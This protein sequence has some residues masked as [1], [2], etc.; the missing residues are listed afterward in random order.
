LQQHQILLVNSG[1][2]MNVEKKYGVGSIIQKIWS[3][4]LRQYVSDV[5]FI[6]I[7]EFPIV[8][9]KVITVN[10]YFDN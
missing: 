2:L 4:H 1:V 5:N 9:T 8:Y 10:K 7:L 6:L 3:T